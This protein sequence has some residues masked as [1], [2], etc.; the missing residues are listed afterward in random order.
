MLPFRIASRTLK[1]D[2]VTARWCALSPARQRDF[3]FHAFRHPRVSV[4]VCV[5]DGCPRRRRFMIT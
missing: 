3:L 2:C 4:T 1:L 5:C